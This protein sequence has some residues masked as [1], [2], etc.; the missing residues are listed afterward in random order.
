FQI[1]LSKAPLLVSS[2]KPLKRIVEEC[3]GGWVFEASNPAVLA[4]RIEEISENP[5]K[6]ELKIE[7]AYVAAIN[8]YNWELGSMNLIGLYKR[9]NG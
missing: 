8:K 6:S 2:C 1:F 9:I 7:N 4:D 5:E 3:D